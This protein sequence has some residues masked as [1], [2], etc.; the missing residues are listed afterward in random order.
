M[1]QENDI[2]KIRRDLKNTALYQGWGVDPEMQG[3]C[4][5]VATIIQ[6]AKDT[7]GFP[8]FSINL[9]DGKFVWTAGMFE[10]ATIFNKKYVDMKHNKAKA[11]RDKQNQELL[12]EVESKVHGQHPVSD[13]E[14]LLNSTFGMSDM[15]MLDELIGKYKIDKSGNLEKPTKRTMDIDRYTS[16][17]DEQISKC[18]NM[19][20]AKRREYASNR[21][22]LSNFI[23]AGEL[24]C[25]SPITALTGMMVKHT[26]SIYD[27]L[28]DQDG[29]A[30][31]SKDKWDEKITDQINYLLIL[32]VLLEDE[33]G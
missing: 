25:V 23:R 2:V 27:M 5:Q 16:V 24:Q 12:H 21:N 22:P 13:G 11:I 3:H 15:E 1:Y 10:P 4:G 29:G 7:M 18:Q 17:I 8:T 14:A 28:I 19:L 6:A 32:Q 20:T 26:I 9:D 30:T 33:R 31:F